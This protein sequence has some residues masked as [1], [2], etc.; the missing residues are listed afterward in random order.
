MFSPNNRFD[1][2]LSRL[3][4]PLTLSALA[5]M[6]LNDTVLRLLWPSWWTGKLSDFAW[7]IIAPLLLA[8][9]FA[10]FLPLSMRSRKLDWSLALALGMTGAAFTLV[11]VVPAA[12][13]LATRIMSVLLGQPPALAPDPGDLLALPA[14]GLVAWLWLRPQAHPAP[15]RAAPL[16]TTP[17]RG[18]L[19]LPL[20]GLVLLGDAA[21]PDLGIRCFSAQD[22]RIL[23]SAGY[24]TYASEDGGLHWVYAPDQHSN[25][26][27]Q[28]KQVDGWQQVPG[29]QSGTDYRFQPDQ[30]IQ[31]S[32][33]AGATWQTAFPLKPI[34]EAQQ[35]YLIRAQNGNPYYRPGPLDALA[36]PADLPGAGNMLFAMG[37]QG[38]LIHTPAG[39]WQWSQGADYQHLDTFPTPEAFSVLLDGMAIMA[40]ALVLLIYASLALAWTHHWLRWVVLV[41]AWLDWLAI[42][43]LFPPATATNYTQT[44]SWLGLLALFILLVPL[45]IEQT[46]RLVKRMHPFTP[47]RFSLLLA[48]SLAG[49][50][51]YFL[52][53]ILWVDAL[54]PY[55][56][57]TTLIGILIVVMAVGFSLNRVHQ[58][59][60]GIQ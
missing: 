55:I 52:P 30:E 56:S 19:M 3:I 41:L 47:R 26:T 27:P 7:L 11:K 49:G 15:L 50:L 13:I 14:L 39:Q 16:R 48:L 1:S 58:L 60:K 17:L 21:A 51:L 31:V 59:G 54:L 42:D 25:C 37:Q 45:V 12:N 6:W 34:S 32:T 18:L 36:V 46:F 5:L 40:L 4:H 43:L 57:T 38:V 20:V 28:T 29:P 22:G 53:Y 10:L 44:A 8:V 35:T 23:A 2:A 33:D 24:K 9:V